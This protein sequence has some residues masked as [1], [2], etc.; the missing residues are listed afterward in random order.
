MLKEKTCLILGA[1]ASR[2]YLLPTSGELRNI[3]L[4]GEHAEKAFKNLEWDSEVVSDPVSFYDD[5]LKELRVEKGLLQQFRREF[6]NAQRVSIDSFLS[7]RKADFESV[8]KLAIATAILI[9]ENERRLN[10]NWYQWLL[11][12]I[13]EDGPDF[14]ATQLSVITFNY[15]RS[16]ER[17]LWRAFRHSFK[18]SNGQADQML[19]R[20]EILHVYGD[21]GKFR[22]SDTFEYGSL[23]S[24]LD[25][26]WTLRSAADDVNIV[27]PR[28]VPE[29]SARA[30]QMIQEAERICFLG[31]GFWK[32]NLDLLGF[33]GQLLKPVFASCYQLSRGIKMD[34][35][36]RFGTTDHAFPTVNFGTPD[37]DVLTFL[38]HWNALR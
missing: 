7:H 8:G 24:L 27:A 6:F 37:Q 23:N 36:E 38:T 14:P 11:E 21:V 16:L 9:C 35:L 19:K 15:D 1:G 34:V 10:A 4:G 17:F 20:I 5:L 3:I 29:T 18:T 22:G 28:A 2:P 26:P 31:F 33:K 25:K 32:E 13:I 12:R 30:S